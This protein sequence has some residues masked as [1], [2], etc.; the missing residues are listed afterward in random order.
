MDD[1]IEATRKVIAQTQKVKQGLLQE[2]LTRGIGHDRFKQTEIGVIPEEWQTVELKDVGK[3]YSGGTPSKR[4]EEYWAGEIPWV[5][6]KDMKTHRLKDTIDHVSESSLSNGT[7]LLPANTILIVVRGMILAH[8]FPVCIT[9]RP[10]AFNQ[11]IK[12]IIAS[13]D[14]HSEFLLFMFAWLKDKILAIINEAT[15][16]TKRLP[17]QELHSMRIPKPPLSEQIR[18]A[19]IL[20]SIDDKITAQEKELERLQILKKG[21][22]QDL[23]T[24]KVRVKV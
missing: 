1:T 11:D 3:W 19:D 2:L 20:N 15:H 7:R 6:P 10:M 8:S 16:G 22:M 18:I 9:M 5:S 24:G 13:R 17:T 4:K 14:F 12:A 21:L 23:L